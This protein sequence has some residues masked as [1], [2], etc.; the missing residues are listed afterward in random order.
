MASWATTCSASTLMGQ[1]REAAS[2]RVPFYEPALKR[3]G[4]ASLQA[5]WV[6]RPPSKKPPGCR[7]ISS[8]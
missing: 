5:G 2:W 7:R 4:A 8:L 3:C 1:A 6:S